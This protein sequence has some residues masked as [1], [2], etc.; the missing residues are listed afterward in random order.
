MA[1]AER[2]LEPDG[3]FHR[4]SRGVI[5]NLDHVD[6]MERDAF[7]LDDGSEVRI[8]RRGVAAAR[9]AWYGRGLRR[10]NPRA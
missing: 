8:S 9:D 2:A 1:A 4:C 7:V 10:L 5:V 6:R 3:R